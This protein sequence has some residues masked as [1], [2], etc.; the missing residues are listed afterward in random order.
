MSK[1][2]TLTQ[3]QVAI[4]D[5][6]DFDKVNKYK[7]YAQYAPS[8]KSFYAMRAI[9]I[10]NTNKNKYIYM[11][12][13]I[14]DLEKGDKREIDHINHYTLDNRKDNLRVCTRRQNHANRKHHS[15]YGI[16]ISFHKKNK[17][18]QYEAQVRI[19]TKTV[20]IGYYDTI[21]EAQNARQ[22]FISR[23]KE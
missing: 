11:H 4:V 15:K 17:T 21:K 12:R 10:S 3:N 8:I 5:D 19:N 22:D 14:M 2:I 18:R 6:E 13:F 1:N 7:W 23:L 9:K 16:G 20:S